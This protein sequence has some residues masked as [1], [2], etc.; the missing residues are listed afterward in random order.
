MGTGL[1]MRGT[2]GGAEG[3]P[4]SFRAAHESSRLTRVTCWSDTISIRWTSN[5]WPND[6]VG[7]HSSGGKVLLV[8][9][10]SGLG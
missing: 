4:C 7:D 6:A 1:F 5:S 10:G 9:P 3:L 8:Y 2:H